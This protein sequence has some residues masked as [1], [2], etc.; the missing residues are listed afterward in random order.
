MTNLLQNKG[1]NRSLSQHFVTRFIHR[2]TQ[3]SSGYAHTL[4]AKRASVLDMTIVEEFFAEFSRL[5]AEYNVDVED[6]YNMDETGFQIDQRKAE[7]VVFNST[8]SSPKATKSEN[9][10]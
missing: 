3:L 5:K 4:D 7:Y 9:A 8:Q 6:I 10:N 1:D 2:H